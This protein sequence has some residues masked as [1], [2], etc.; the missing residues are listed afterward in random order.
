MARPSARAHLLLSGQ[1]QTTSSGADNRSTQRHAW[2]A[3]PRRPLGDPVVKQ[4]VKNLV[5]KKLVKQR[6]A[7]AAP[8]RRPHGG[9]SVAKKL[10]KQLAPTRTGTVRA[11]RVGWVHA[12]GP[13]SRSSDCRRR[14][15]I[16]A[17]R[18]AA[19][20]AWRPGLRRQ[21]APEI[22][23]FHRATRTGPGG[24]NER[25]PGHRVDQ[26]VAPGLH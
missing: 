7:W 25:R 9:D 5:V 2:A 18:L 3:P 19:P 14:S 21:P 11:R 10:V 23:Q 1:V 12:G 20:A 8:P 16:R 24:V 17:S 6:R 4:L 13:R 26:D 22:A 15:A